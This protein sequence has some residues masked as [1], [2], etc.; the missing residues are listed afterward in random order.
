MLE[1]YIYLGRNSSIKLTINRLPRKEVLNR[2]TKA[3]SIKPQSQN[4]SAIDILNI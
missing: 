3:R 4:L 1:M 2:I